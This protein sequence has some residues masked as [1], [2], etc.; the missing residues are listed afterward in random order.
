MG[1]PRPSVKRSIYRA[2]R[3]SRIRPTPSLLIYAIVIL[4]TFFAGPPLLLLLQ[5]VYP[6]DWSP[7]S[8]IGQSYT[9]MSALLS[10]AALVAVA[11]SIQFQGREVRI[12][13]TL[14]VHDSQRELIKMAFD[15]PSLLPCIADF[16]EP[17]LR[18]K[19]LT[20]N[21]LW[22]RYYEL[23]YGTGYMSA[24]RLAFVLERERF[25]LALVREHWEKVGDFWKKFG[26]PE[27][28]SIVDQSYRAAKDKATPPDSRLHN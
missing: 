12:S 1:S 2:R 10:A 21:T 24:E 23:S 18:E 3:F 25:P 9:G 26:T 27:F 16:A 11:V 19:Q 15:D 17:D 4:G 13:Q 28:V 14:A 7:L 5:R 20:Y 6:L 8:S 22:L